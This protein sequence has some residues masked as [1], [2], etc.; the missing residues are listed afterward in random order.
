LGD[1]R[2]KWARHLAWIGKGEMHMGFW[3]GNLRERHHFDDLDID[4]RITLNWFFKNWHGKSENG[5][6]LFWMGMGG[7]LLGKR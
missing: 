6:I 2:I 4:A 7:G 1:Q 5:K 3:W